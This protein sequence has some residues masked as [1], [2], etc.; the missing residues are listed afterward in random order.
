MKE[1]DS[2]S[3]A[4]YLLD[5]GEDKIVSIVCFYKID[6]NEYYVP[7]VWTS[8]K[9][10]GTGAFGRLIAWLVVYVKSK[11]GKRISTDVHHDNEP[12]VKL[13]DRYWKRTFVR[14]NLSLR[15]Q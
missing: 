12:M 7:I 15:G 3:E 10:R 8:E 13:M 4:V 5:V 14:F 9:Y 1:L 6:G 2:E 11:R